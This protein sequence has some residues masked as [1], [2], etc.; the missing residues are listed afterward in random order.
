MYVHSDQR[1]TGLVRLLSIGL[2]VLTLLEFSLALWDLSPGLY[3]QLCVE[4]P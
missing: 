4:F 2:R 3:D 1:A